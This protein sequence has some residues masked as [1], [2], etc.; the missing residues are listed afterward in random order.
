LDSL[1]SGRREVYIQPLPPLKG[2]TRVSINGGR[3]PSWR[4]AGKELYFVGPDS[5]LMAADTNLGSTATAGIPR[6]LFRTAGGITGYD[7][8]SDGQRFLVVTPT[9]ALPDNPITVV[10]NWWADLKP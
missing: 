9:A 7:I 2:R 6:P 3:N 8:Q 5:T 4:R 10:V 1:E